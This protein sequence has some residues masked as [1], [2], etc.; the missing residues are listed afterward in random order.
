MNWPG[1]GREQSNEVLEVGTDDCGRGHHS[2][3]TVVYHHGFPDVV[4]AFWL[5][6]G[7]DKAMREIKFRGYSPDLDQWVYGDL[8]HSELIQHPTVA[9]VG[10]DGDA[11]EVE[12]ESVGQFTGCY[13][14]YGSAIYEGDQ[15]QDIFDVYTFFG[16]RWKENG[17]I[18]GRI[19]ED[20]TY[21]YLPL[22]DLL[23]GYS[24][25]TQG[26]EYRPKG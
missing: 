5:M 17:F 15:L 13:D 26:P 11:E 10:D 7:E 2:V 14:F 19:D 21:M 22:R 25:V 9:I 4:S 16:V 23:D 12:P 18:G 6:E 8:F 3:G 24:L 1:W 20:G